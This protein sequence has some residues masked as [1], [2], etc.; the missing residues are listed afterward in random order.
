MAKIEKIRPVLL[1]APYA[2][3][4][5][6]LEV[7]LHLKSGLRT[8]GLVEITLDNGITGLGEGYLAVFAPRVFEQIVHLISPHLVG[9][10]VSDN[11]ALLR[12]LSLIIN[13]WSMQG[14]ARHVFSAFEIALL[15]CC[16]K[17]QGVP[18][19]KML[20]PESKNTLQLYGSGGDSPL[21]RFMEEE[22]KYLTGLGIG[23]FKIR[24]RNHQ[25]NKAIWC[26]ERGMASD[27]KIAIDM[28]QNLADPGQSIHEILQFHRQIT[29][30]TN[31]APFF[32][33]E[34][35][36][37]HNGSAY[38]ELRS[39]IPVKIA[40]GEIVTTPEE[41][42]GR[43][44]N[45]WYDIAQPDASVIGGIQAVLDVFDQ[46][47]KMDTEVIVHS[48]GGPVGM[49][50]NYHAALAGG[51]SMAEWPMPTYELRNAMKDK[52]WS[53]DRGVLKLDDTPGLGVSLNKHIEQ[54]FA[55]R[56]EAIYSCLTDPSIV[57]DDQHWKK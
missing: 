17:L 43:I 21:P 14:A 52:P 2:Q 25:V 54:A 56:E 40:G 11:N 5:E 7:D 39:Q 28:T 8:T 42:A 53:I 18:V 33:E 19:Y 45:R 26:M 24:A 51:G 32:F 6:N 46:A 27:I 15:D 29:S 50:A 49:M 22:F 57:P 48:W 37:V 9:R 4:G 34:V 35:L 44:R 3:S 30:N 16:A 12:D 47:K 1:S 41:L 36:G 55:F 38:P 20:N 23:H 13:Y 10:E 31:A